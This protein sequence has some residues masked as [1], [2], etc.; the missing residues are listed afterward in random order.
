MPS[1]SLIRKNENYYSDI[2]KAGGKVPASKRMTSFA[3]IVSYFVWGTSFSEYFGYRF[4]EKSIREKKT[5][6]T[7]RHMFKFF[8]KYN[9]PEYRERIGDKSLAPKYY[10]AFLNREQVE[11]N[12]GFDAFRCFCEKYG[13]VFFKKK[14]GWG[15]EG[16]ASFEVGDPDAV[17]NAWEAFTDEFVAEPLLE[18]CD[19][20]KAIHPKSLNTMKLTVLQTKQGPKIVTAIIRFGNDTVVDNI[21]SGGMAAG[22]DIDTGIIE[23]YAMDKH[24]QQYACHPLTGQQIKG[25]AIPMWGETK[26]LAIR[27]SLVTPQLRYT[28]WDI[29]LTNNG[30][31]MIE[32]NWD[33]E[34]YMEQTLYNRGHRI[35]FTELLEGQL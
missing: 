29:A 15:G 1:L 7:R 6:M 31:I 14:V 23:T 13:K 8:D 11:K 35:L 19:E 28:S 24:F 25:M 22:I 21:H 18:N 16:A 12:M 2:K 20:I 17:K 5:Y 33:A 27:A 30:P 26:E 34:F 9:P 4:W 10:G 32:G 3:A